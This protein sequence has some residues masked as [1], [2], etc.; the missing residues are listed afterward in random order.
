MLIIVEV[1]YLS[2]SPLQQTNAHM[3]ILEGE[4]DIIF[5]GYHIISVRDS[6]QLFVK[7]TQPLFKCITV[8]S[9]CNQ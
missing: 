5:E 1:P 4:K 9:W 8:F 2:E 7:S 6:L 3:R